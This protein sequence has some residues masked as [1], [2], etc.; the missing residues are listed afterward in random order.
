MPM[1][2]YGSAATFQRTMELILQGL[3]WTTAIIYIDD[4]TGETHIRQYLL[5]RKFKIRSDHQALIWLFRL[6]EP[7]GRIARWIEVLSA[8]TFSIEYRAGKK[9]GHAGALSRCDNPHDCDCPNI[10]TLE[11]LKC[12]PCKK[13][14]KRAE[15]MNLQTPDK[16]QEMSKNNR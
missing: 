3:Q 8:Y 7:R 16:R 15:A 13:C 10:N 4:I 11:P 14:L 12:G 1:G 2:L 5:E 6:K 9:M